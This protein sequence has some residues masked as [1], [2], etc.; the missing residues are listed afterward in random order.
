MKDDNSEHLIN[1]AVVQKWY[2]YLYTADKTSWFNLAKK[3][4]SDIDPKI[5]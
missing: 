3:R 1:A 2:P 4:M 5:Y